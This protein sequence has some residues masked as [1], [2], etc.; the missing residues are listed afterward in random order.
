MA[1]GAASGAGIGRHPSIAMRRG[2]EATQIHLDSVFV[3]NCLGSRAFIE[4]AKTA[5]N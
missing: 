3:T 4:P 2:A 5:I 1:W